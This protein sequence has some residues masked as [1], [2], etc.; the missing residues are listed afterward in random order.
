M[1]TDTAVRVTRMVIQDQRECSEFQRTEAV[2][3]KLLTIIKVTLKD[4][5]YVDHPDLKINEHESTEMPFRYVKDEA[6]QPIMPKV[7]PRIEFSTLL[8][9]ASC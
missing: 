2:S 7:S 1:T 6:G 8:L 3:G 9:R 5:P 4:I